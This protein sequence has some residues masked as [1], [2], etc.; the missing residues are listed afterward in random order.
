MTDPLVIAGVLRDLHPLIIALGLGAARLYGLLIVMPLFTRMGLT[1]LLR[2]G[3]SL[4]LA[5]PLLPLLTPMVASAPPAGFTSLALLLMKELAIGLGIGALFSVPFWAGE[6]IDQQR[7]SQA[8]VVMDATATNQT[9]IT[10]TLLSLT[11]ITLF[12]IAGGM[13]FMIDAVFDSYRIWGALDPTPHFPRT[14]VTGCS[15]CSISCC[16]A[17]SCWRRRC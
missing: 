3:V 15:V 17:A 10:G 13:R 9:G 7:G 2:G 4:G 5:V 8:A 12:L 14:A 11:R 6:I 16:A 1:G